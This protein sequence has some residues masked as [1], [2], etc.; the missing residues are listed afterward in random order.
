MRLTRHTDYALRVLIYL[1]V[2]P[3]QR[4]SIRDVADAYGIS[5]NHLT[6]VAQ[7]LQRGG[8]IRT[9]RGQGGGISLAR[10]PSEIN[11][12]EVTRQLERADVLVECMG[13]DGNCPIAPVCELRG[14]LAAALEAF[15]AVL[16]NY[17]LA[18]LAGGRRRDALRNLLQL[19]EIT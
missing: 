4:V 13:P 10:S 12:G 15:M 18:D 17:T 2:H 7:R 16:E 9:A 14:A 5:H 1:S 8:W 3:A 6:K 19:T 11:V